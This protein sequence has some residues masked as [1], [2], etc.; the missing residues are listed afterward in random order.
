M[1]VLF[2]SGG[3]GKWYYHVYPM[4]GYMITSGSKEKMC[5]MPAAWVTPL[6][7]D[8]PLIGVA[9]SKKRYTYKIII[10]TKKF[11]VNSVGI[12]YHRQVMCA[13]SYSCKEKEKK[14]EDC[15]FNIDFLEDYGGLPVVKE[16]YS[17]VV[18]RVKDIV[19]TGDHDFIIGEV[20][21]AYY[22]GNGYMSPKDLVYM[23]P[24]L[25]VGKKYFTTVVKK[26][27]YE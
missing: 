14:L 3:L 2:L 12:K 25:H 23:E 5:G 9:I 8:P 22:R 7:L 17:V 15:G 21:K 6:S 11:A 24:I 19:E 18:A 10:S 1:K 26:L 4:R 13:G 27:F 20:L 16:S